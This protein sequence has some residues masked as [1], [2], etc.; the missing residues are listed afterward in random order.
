MIRTLRLPLA[1]VVF[2]FLFLSGSAHAQFGGYALFSVE[3]Q[4]GVQS[5][6]L[7]APGVAYNN[8]VNPLGFT[9]GAFY[10][11][12]SYGPVRLGVDARGSIVTTKRGAQAG[13]DGAGT[14]TGSGLLGVRAS[15][16]TPVKYIK[17][18]VQGSAGLGRSNFGILYP[19][20]T[21]TAGSGLANA[22]EYH[23]YVGMDLQFVPFADWRVFEAGYGALT[24]SG[25]G[26]ASHTYPVLSISTGIV[27][28][29]SR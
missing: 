24:S 22:F 7:L 11:F 25:N 19:S 17:P 9:G 16:H 26:G 29:L 14:K 20:G 1:V 8:A 23:G 18:Y 5:S 21:T 27:F 12:K 4:S 6:P 10:D 3:H 15:F 28:H 2:A 13:S